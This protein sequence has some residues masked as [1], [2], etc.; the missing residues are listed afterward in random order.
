M[1]LIVRH[2]F[3]DLEKNDTENRTKK[4][5]KNILECQDVAAR[6]ECVTVSVD[7]NSDYFINNSPI[8]QQEADMTNQ[9]NVEH[10]VDLGALCQLNE[11]HQQELQQNMCSSNSKTAD[12]Y[13]HINEKVS[14]S[15]QSNSDPNHIRSSNVTQAADLD[16]PSQQNNPS[17]QA[18][19]KQN[20]NNNF[21][22][23]HLN[24]GATAQYYESIKKLFENEAS[25]NLDL[26]WNMWKS[27]LNPSQYNAIDFSMLNNPSLVN[28]YMKQILDYWH[29][30]MQNP[31]LGNSLLYP[32]QY[33]GALS[34][35]KA[36]TNVHSATLSSSPTAIKQESP[37]FSK[38]ENPDPNEHNVLADKSKESSKQTKAKEEVFLH[39][40]E[41]KPLCLKNGKKWPEEDQGSLKGSCTI[42]SQNSSQNTPSPSSLSSFSDQRSNSAKSS[43]TQQYDKQ[44]K[45]FA[46]AFYPYQS[47]P[48]SSWLGYPG[49]SGLPNHFAYN[50]YS[51]SLQGKDL[52]KKA[53]NMSKSGDKSKK[54]AASPVDTLL[55]LNTKHNSSPSHLPSSTYDVYAESKAS[56][57]QSESITSQAPNLENSEAVKRGLNLPYVPYSSYWLGSVLPFNSTIPSPYSGMSLNAKKSNSKSLYPRDFM[58]FPG[59]TY[60][61]SGST[62]FPESLYKRDPTSMS[63]MLGSRRSRSRGSAFD[64]VHAAI[65]RE[66]KEQSK[67]VDPENMYIQCPICQKRIKRLYHFQRHMRIHTGE[68]THQCPCCQYKSVRKDN[69]K[70]H[71]KTHE[72]QNLEG[73]KKTGKFPNQNSRNSANSVEKTQIHSPGASSS[74]KSADHVNSSAVSTANDTCLN[75]S[76]QKPCLDLSG[77]DNISTSQ[78]LSKSQFSDNFTYQNSI[79]NDLKHAGREVNK[80]S[81]ELSPNTSKTYNDNLKRILN[82]AYLE[83]KYVEDREKND[84]CAEVNLSFSRPKS[85]LII[86]NV[87]SAEKKPKKRDLI[88]HPLQYSGSEISNKRRKLS[89]EGSRSGAC[90]SPNASNSNNNNDRTKSDKKSSFDKT[91]DCAENNFAKT[92][93]ISTDEIPAQAMNNKSLNFDKKD[94]VTLAEMSLNQTLPFR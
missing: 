85:E 1:H 84:S 30:T 21:P 51:S 8:V 72:K 86:D 43:H 81:P 23:Y 67:G 94:L 88:F 63:K 6:G 60:P 31:S 78:P 15:I 71:M 91:P 40:R 53:R 44:T 2:C 70:S 24:S 45:P 68:K 66:A 79:I 65:V 61:P 89:R 47:W 28:G 54:D 73:G 57:K 90:L 18:K 14:D 59:L 50:S 34:T 42:S 55:H 22:T 77:G 46:N 93:D 80:M 25:K 56:K 19:S 11:G 41:S 27:G 69:L 82:G 9:Q 74:H 39:D 92:S 3:A 29:A 58:Q 49:F 17:D 33:G 5:T 83:K 20:P 75:L 36:T 38:V 26:N 64:S 32:F 52:P 35:S 4:S 87:P 37:A 10:K 16:S 12:P 62:Y 7:S 13:L 48:N 76:L